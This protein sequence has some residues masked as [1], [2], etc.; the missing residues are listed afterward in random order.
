[1]GFSSSYDSEKGISMCSSPILPSSSHSKVL[2]ALS[3]AS[4]TPSKKIPRGLNQLVLGLP[5][6]LCLILT[7]QSRAAQPQA[8]NS[9]PFPPN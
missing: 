7:F 8:R 9:A 1:M 3:T 6:Q 2:A 4:V 5:A